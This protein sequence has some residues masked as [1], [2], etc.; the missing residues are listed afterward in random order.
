MLN[1]AT[2]LEVRRL[3]DE[4]RLSQRKIAKAVGVSRATVGA[5][6]NGKRALFGRDDPQA[7]SPDGSRCGYSRCP[8][9]GARVVAPCVACAALR[10]R[11]REQPSELRAA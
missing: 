3:L 7:P 9:C 11:A 10:Y 1:R 8:T 6:A 4:G 2:V 5:I